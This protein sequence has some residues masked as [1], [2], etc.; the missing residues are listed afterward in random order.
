MQLWIEDKYSGRGFLVKGNNFSDAIC[1]A[2][3]KCSTDL[4]TMVV[5]CRDTYASEWQRAAEVTL[6]GCT[7]RAPQFRV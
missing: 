1:Q 7:W 5:W 4:D 3:E 2:S 6:R